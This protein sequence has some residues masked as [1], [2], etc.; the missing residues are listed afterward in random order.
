MK[1]AIKNVQDSCFKKTICLLL[2]LITLAFSA[3]CNRQQEDAEQAFDWSDYVIVT[4][5]LGIPQ[6]DVGFGRKTNM[7]QE[8]KE[9]IEKVSG[10]F[11]DHFHES[12]VPREHEIQI[13]FTGRE[14]SEAL[15]G[16]LRE[17]DWVVAYRNGNFIICGG[18][19]DA[20]L[21]AIRAFIREIGNIRPGIEDGDLVR[22][23]GKYP[24]LIPVIINGTD[25]K[26][27][28]FSKVKDCGPPATLYFSDSFYRK[29]GYKTHTNG[30]KDYEAYIP[31]ITNE[32]A[33]YI[34]FGFGKDFYDGAPE[35]E[36]GTAVI[37]CNGSSIMIY[38]YGE[39]QDKYKNL[40]TYLLKVIDEAPLVDRKKEVTIPEGVTIIPVG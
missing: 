25:I 18:S 23:T 16:E 19:D 11:P 15:K 37:L 32:R 35:A 14:E 22:Y 29:Y 8:I 30:V 12:S 28:S 21:A 17:N 1:K 10:Y 20:L 38:T 39:G 27:F 31:S 26:E 13:G 7:L 4:P 24:E 36:E 6:E 9:A 33:H 5:N 34:V 3:S 40:H 2:A